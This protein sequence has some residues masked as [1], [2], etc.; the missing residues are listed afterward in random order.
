LVLAIIA[1]SPML[2]RAT[3]LPLQDDNV[4]DAFDRRNAQISSHQFND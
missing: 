3:P 1:G 2:P 4:R